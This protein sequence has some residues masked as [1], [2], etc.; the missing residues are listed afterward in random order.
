MKKTWLGGV[1]GLLVLVV[2]MVVFWPQQAEMPSQVSEDIQSKVLISEDEHSVL[3]SGELLLDTKHEQLVQYLR[4]E[5]GLCEESNM[6]RTP[7]SKRFCE[8]LDFFAQEV[9]FSDLQVDP[10]S[11]AVVFAVRT[12]QLEPDNFLVWLSLATKDLQVLTPFYLGNEF[13]G[14]SSKGKLFAYRTNCWEGM[15]GIKVGQ[16]ATGLE[17]ASFNNPEQFD[18]REFD[19]QFVGWDSEVGLY[20]RLDGK[21]V[22]GRIE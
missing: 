10:N 4:E 7:T 9:F 19:A 22:L 17:V 15:C 6:N 8:D 18:S 13:L 3:R 2:V 20:Y 21:Q 1:V 12:K 5:T 14:F 11:Q 16:T